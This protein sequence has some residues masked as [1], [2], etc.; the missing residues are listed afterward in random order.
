M[1]SSNCPINPSVTGWSED[2]ITRSWTSRHPLKGG[3]KTS[4]TPED[5]QNILSVVGERGSE[6]IQEMIN[7]YNR[8]GSMI[9]A[10]PFAG[11]VAR[12]KKSQ[13]ASFS[14]TGLGF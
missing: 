12:G 8:F 6:D 5:Y 14:S 2:Y 13:F 4:P 1:P 9:G 10:T 3:F 11:K 7:N